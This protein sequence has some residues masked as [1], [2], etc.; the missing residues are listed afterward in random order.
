MRYD[1]RLSTHQ[2]PLLFGA[3]VVEQTKSQSKLRQPF[4]VL[5]LN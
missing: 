2:S 1:N 3:Q 5:Y 4:L